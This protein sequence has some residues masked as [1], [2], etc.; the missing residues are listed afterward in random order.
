MT[1]AAEKRSKHLYR[2]LAQSRQWSVSVFQMSQRDF[3]DRVNPSVVSDIE[4]QPNLHSVVHFKEEILRNAPPYGA[5]P[6][7]WLRDV[8]EIRSQELNRRPCRELSNSPSF[9]RTAIKRTVARSLRHEDAR[10]PAQR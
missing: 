3:D 8:S 7:Q 10:I 9:A 1:L 4:E 2:L 5:L 6:R